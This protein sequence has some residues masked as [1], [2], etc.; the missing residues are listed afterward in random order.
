MTFSRDNRPSVS[1]IMKHSEKLTDFDRFMHT[2]S[3]SGV[4]Q[5]P[6]RKLPNFGRNWVP[7]IVQLPVGGDRGMRST[8]EIDFSVHGGDLDKPSWFLTNQGKAQENLPSKC[9]CNNPRHFLFQFS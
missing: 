1:K 6:V 8:F 3:I 5:N 9:V 4:R 7:L 2:Q